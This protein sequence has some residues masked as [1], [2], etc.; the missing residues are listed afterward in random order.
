MAQR[1]PSLDDLGEPREF[2]GQAGGSLDVI[3]DYNIKYKWHRKCWCRYVPQ[4]FRWNRLETTEAEQVMR[5]D[6][7]TIRDDQ[8]Q[9]RF[10]LTMKQLR[11][12]D[13]GTYLCGIQA[14][15]FS[16]VLPI[17]VTI[18]PAPTSALTTTSMSTM[19]TMTTDTP[20][21]TATTEEI[22]DALSVTRTLS[23]TTARAQDSPSG[24][25]GST[26]SWRTHRKFRSL[27]SIIHFL[28]PVFLKV[29][30]L[31]VLMGAIV[32]AQLLSGDPKKFLVK[33]EDP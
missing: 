28:L 4:S 5:S 27:L 1:L 33:L 17:R 29:L 22:T 25:I 13:T 18:S 12:D 14:D 26:E 24:P 11:D 31:L 3:C 21:T 23:N 15:T 20:T 8:S 10:T 9:N 6:Q 2:V 7:V 32:W 19:T 30:L 16:L